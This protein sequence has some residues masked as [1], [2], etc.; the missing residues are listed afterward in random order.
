M[1]S[2]GSKLAIAAVVLVASLKGKGARLREPVVI[3]VSRQDRSNVA[4]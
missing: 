2:I 1:A 4:K 3:L